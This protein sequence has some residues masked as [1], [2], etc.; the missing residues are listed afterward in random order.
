MSPKEEAKKQKRGERHSAAWGKRVSLLVLVLAAE[1]ALAQNWTGE[2]RPV[3][4]FAP[5]LA[6]MVE[7]AHQGAA[8]N[9]TVRVIVQYK[10]VPQAAHEG[11][12]QQM[13]ARLGHRLG[14]VNALAATIPASALPALEAD[15]EVV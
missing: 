1:A 9:E 2:G 13:G 15:S 8:A 11:R 7:R 14:M 4:K 12:L 10:S 5:D 3:E 6:P